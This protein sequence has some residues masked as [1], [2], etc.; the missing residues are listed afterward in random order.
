M[1]VSGC[2]HVC[3]TRVYSSVH[4]EGLEVWLR[5]KSHENIPGFVKIRGQM[6]TYLSIQQSSWATPT[7]LHNLPEIY[8]NTHD[9]ASL[10]PESFSLQK[11]LRWSDFSMLQRALQP[12]LHFLIDI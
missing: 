11:G 2:F 12:A 3:F 7:L 9:P 10:W 6:Y 5:L 1:T 4:G 8:D